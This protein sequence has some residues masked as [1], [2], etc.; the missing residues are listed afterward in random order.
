MY[1]VRVN[2]TNKNKIKRV[3]KLELNWKKLRRK[4]ETELSKMVNNMMV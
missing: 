3:K 4:K 1:L 2:R